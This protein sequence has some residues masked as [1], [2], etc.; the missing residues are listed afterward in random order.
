M[1]RG[2]GWLRQA[3]EA[4]ATVAEAQRL[5]RELSGRVDL[6][7]GLPGAPGIVAGLDVSYEVGTRQVAAAAVSLAMPTLEV[8]ESV[9]VT[10]EVTFPYVPGLLAFR[11]APFLLA[12]LD[13]LTTRPDV[14]VCD[15]YGIAHPRR[16]G[17]ACHV[18]VLA[19]LPTFGVA[20]TAFTATFEEPGKS[21]GAWSPL[22]DGDEILGRVVRT[23]TGVKPVFVSVGH[24][25]SLDEAT[26][27]TLALCDRYRIPEAIR[28]ADQVS[29]E[30]LRQSP[31]SGVEVD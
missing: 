18:G 21:R 22:F 2:N 5:Q 8:R 9:V 1:A 24:R 11:E 4:P 20:K 30:S 13:R 3:P 25:I 7:T 19:D 28:K 10:G 17:L 26:G 27:L 14:L 15:G 6:T 12:A 16:F 23:Q 29:R 31:T